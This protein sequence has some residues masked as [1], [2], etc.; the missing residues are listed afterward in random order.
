MTCLIYIFPSIR[1]SV[2]FLFPKIKVKQKGFVYEVL[3]TYTYND[4]IQDPV[5]EKQNK[6]NTMNVNYTYVTDVNS[7]L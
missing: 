3:M 6:K 5:Y 7:L 4:F 2:C 1:F